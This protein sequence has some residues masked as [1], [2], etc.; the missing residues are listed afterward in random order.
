MNRC[1]ESP[2]VV[3]SSAWTWRCLTCNTTG[4]QETAVSGDPWGRAKRPV[5]K[6]VRVHAGE[7]YTRGYVDGRA[8][9]AWEIVKA[10]V[11]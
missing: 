2:A 4:A 10:S 7:D 8:A 9:A 3:W 11:L 5:F 6:T 1:C